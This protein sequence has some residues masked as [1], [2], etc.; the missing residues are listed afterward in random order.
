MVFI[1]PII[2]NSAK[3][4][5]QVTG[6]KYFNLRKKQLKWMQDYPYEKDNKDMIFK[7]MEK[8][9]VLPLPF[10]IKKYRGRSFSN[11]SREN[12]PSV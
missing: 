6:S 10:P 11:S 3:T 4:G 12:S 2:L 9:A 5:L 7:P 8:S 1:R